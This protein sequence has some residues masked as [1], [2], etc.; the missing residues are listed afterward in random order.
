ME[1]FLKVFN[2]VCLAVTLWLAVI[3]MAEDDKDVKIALGEDSEDDQDS[4]VSYSDYDKSRED[5][6]YT[7]GEFLNSVLEN[8]QSNLEST[9]QKDLS[10]NSY[11]ESRSFQHESRSKSYESRSTP[12]YSDSKDYD[13][14]DYSN[15]NYDI[16]KPPAVKAAC[17]NQKDCLAAAKDLGYAA[18]GQGF[19]FAGNYFAKGCYTY[20]TGKYHGHIYYGTCG[21]KSQKVIPLKSPKSRIM[22]TKCDKSKSEGKEFAEETFR[23]EMIV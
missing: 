8:S 13:Y 18:G 1:T 5:K 2:R 20:L 10:S 15:D 7:S 19:S 23:I 6:K 14:Q 21:K 3:V 17:T 4:F 11:Y 12:E 16:K 22:S 9:S